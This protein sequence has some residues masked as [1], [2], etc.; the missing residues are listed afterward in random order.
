GARRAIGDRR[1]RRQHDCRRGVNA[2]RPQQRERQG[3][4]L[5]DGAKA[6]PYAR[7]HQNMTIAF[8]QASQM[9]ESSTRN[10]LPGESM[11]AGYFGFGMPV[12]TA[13]LLLAPRHGPDAARLPLKSGLHG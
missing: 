5:R 10:L 12:A 11:V 3:R 2:G 4:K 6:D 1:H 7:G 13:P 8:T 9:L